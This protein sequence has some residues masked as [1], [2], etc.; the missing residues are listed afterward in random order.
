MLA[1]ARGVSEVIHIKN[2]NTLSRW[3]G[4]AD[5]LAAVPSV[6]LAQCVMQM[7]YDFYLNRGVPEFM[8]FVMT[9][10]K[11]PPKD[12]KEIKDAISANIGRG[13][14]HKSLAVN[15]STD[16]TVEL[17]KLGMDE[18]GDDGFQTTRETLALDV[19]TAH[20]TPPLLA[21][22]QIP[23]KLGAN[24]ELPNA[25]M[26]FQ[27][28]VIGPAQYTFQSALGDTLGNSLDNGGLGLVFDDFSLKT[29]LDSIDIGIMSTVG[30][31]KQPVT[32]ATAQG[33]DV[34]AGLKE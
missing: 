21:G 3:Y 23:G 29:I 20:R 31:M 16:D 19:V 2:H 30:G 34:G 28:L 8:L 15:L 13:N 14:S 9:K 26:A 22:I 12:W 4:F 7:K 11:M 33:R 32:A 25:L 18:S 27:V 5:W 10:Q 24:N 6:D 1:D 17:E